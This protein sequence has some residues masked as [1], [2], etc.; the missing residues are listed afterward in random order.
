MEIFLHFADISDMRDKR[1]HILYI[2]VLC[3]KTSLTNLGENSE[4]NS[5]MTLD[6]GSRDALM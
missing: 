3:G 1:L 4:S 6:A 5:T 2:K